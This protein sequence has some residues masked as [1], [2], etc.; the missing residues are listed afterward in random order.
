M[1]S[2][3]LT[4]VALSAVLL[5]CQ[6]Q[7]DS[8]KLYDIFSSGTYDLGSADGYGSRT[9]VAQDIGIH[10]CND[11]TSWPTGTQTATSGLTTVS[12]FGPASYGQ[13]ENGSNGD[14]RINN[15]T[16]GGKESHWWPIRA[17]K[18]TSPNWKIMPTF[19]VTDVDMQCDGASDPN[20]P[21]LCL[22]KAALVFGYNG[23]NLVFPNWDL[24]GN[25]MVL[26][27]MRVESPAMNGMGIPRTPIPGTDVFDMIPG[28]MTTWGDRVPQVPVLSC[29]L[30][31]E[32]LRCGGTV[33]FDTPV[34]GIIIA[35]AAE[36]KSE[37]LS[38]ALM[39]V[40]DFKIPEGCRCSESDGVDPRRITEEDPAN[41]GECTVRTEPATHYFCNPLGDSWCKY[42][43]PWYL[44]L[45]IHNDCL[46]TCLLCSHLFYFSR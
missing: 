38:G 26:H 32:D 36:W 35:I 17:I 6:A 46:L 37:T 21:L 40:G 43:A 42:L 29:N 4:I 13:Q 2:L 31:A 18:V 25:T 34:E 1:T 16:A 22:R 44:L 23:A 3:S 39:S 28:I 12:M 19:T 9:L 11:W 10:A 8:Y 15:S 5:L 30:G 7:F 20:D 41:M 14:C 27:D 24:A 33:T 45:R